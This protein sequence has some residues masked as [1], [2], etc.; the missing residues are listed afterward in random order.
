MSGPVAL[1]LDAGGTATRALVVAGGGEV[2]GAGRSGSGNPTA[3]GADPALRAWVSAAH[4]ALQASGRTASDVDAVVVALAGQ[5]RL[6]P[7][8]RL[9]SALGLPRG[10]PV[11]TVGDVL[12]MFR[13]AA[14][15]DDG[16]VAVAGTGSI[17]ARVVGGELGHLVGGS[18]WLVGDAG[19]GFATGRRVARAAVADLDGSGPPTALTGQVLA[20]YGLEDDGERRHGRPAVL[21]ALVDAVYADRP[22]GL[23]RLAPLA[24]SGVH[25][26]VAARVVR[27]THDELASMLGALRRSSGGLGADGPLV[28][29][30]SVFEHAV[31][32]DE[33]RWSPALSDVLRG[34]PLRRAEDGAVG[35]AVMALRAAGARVGA[36]ELAA[37]RSGVPPDDGPTTTATPTT[38]AEE[39]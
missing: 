38:S 33:P 25:D 15:E 24:F 19:S 1:G 34:V 37:L 9:G 18:G 13:S 39:A 20:A 7:T 2:L 14:D 36:V 12:A 21:A 35:A 31:L 5:S 3:A 27:R 23:A 4:A 17:G 26:E 16:L 32:G 28:V 10:V 6:A 22:V 11:R 29:G 30:G 8:D